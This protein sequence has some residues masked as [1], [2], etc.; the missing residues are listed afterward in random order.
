MKKSQ[1]CLQNTFNKFRLTVMIRNLCNL[2]NVNSPFSHKF[3]FQMNKPFL[4][5]ELEIIL[6]SCQ[7]TSPGPDGIS[8]T[9]IH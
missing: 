2:E 3:L 6:K 5:E 7:N 1:T 8:S 9:L 4:L